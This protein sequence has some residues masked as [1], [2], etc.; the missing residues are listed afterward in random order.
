MYSSTAERQNRAKK[1]MPKQYCTGATVLM[2]PAGNVEASDSVALSKATEGTELP[3]CAHE[4][5]VDNVIFIDTTIGL[6]IIHNRV[7]T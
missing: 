5:R 7:K 2:S 6:D 1:E 3:R 4:L